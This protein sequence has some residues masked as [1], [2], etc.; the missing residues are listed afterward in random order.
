MF[1]L[2]CAYNDH[3]AH[4]APTH[5]HPRDADPRRYS[6]AVL[7]NSAGAFGFIGPANELP[8]LMD[9]RSEIDFN[10]TSSIWLTSRFAK[11]F[12][13][14][15]QEKRPVTTPR[16]IEPVATTKPA[17]AAAGTSNNQGVEGNG[18]FSKGNG[19]VVVNLTS[20]FALKPR[21]FWCGY[22]ASKAAREMYHRRV[23]DRNK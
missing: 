11:I 7:V 3:A 18:A 2:I 20:G 16:G 15:G 1:A 19:N 6:Q 9:L 8:S 5:N 10:V 12:G 21:E 14:P 17:A 22:A 4:P 13:V 23:R